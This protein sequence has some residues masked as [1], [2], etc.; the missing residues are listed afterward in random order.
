MLPT[1][2][3]NVNDVTASIEKSKDYRKLDKKIRVSN[4]FEAETTA[5]HNNARRKFEKIQHSIDTISKLRQS[6]RV[7]VT[8]VT[9][10]VFEVHLNIGERPVY[11]QIR[12]DVK[13]NQFFGVRSEPPVDCITK[14][15]KLRDLEEIVSMMSAA[16]KE[17]FRESLLI[18]K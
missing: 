17:H 13:S 15:E 11:F 3:I 2:E 6:G 5:F 7:N 14:I 16:F 4:D 10:D 1:V 18:L 8:H 12:C 9:D